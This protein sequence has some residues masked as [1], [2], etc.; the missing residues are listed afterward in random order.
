MTLFMI[1]LPDWTRQ[2]LHQIAQA[3]GI[4]M[5]EL[6]ERWVL[7]QPDIAEARPPNVHEDHQ[8]SSSSLMR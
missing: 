8:V 6:I 4:S 7:E 3:H 1:Q 2:R 5:P